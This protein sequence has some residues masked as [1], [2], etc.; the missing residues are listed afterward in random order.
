MQTPVNPRPGRPGQMQS[1]YLN[2]QDRT[3]TTY[4]RYSHGHFHIDVGEAGRGGCALNVFRPFAN[5]RGVGQKAY[6]NEPTMNSTP[7]QMH[8]YLNQ[9]KN[10]LQFISV[11]AEFHPVTGSDF[12]TVLPRRLADVGFS[13]VVA[14][15]RSVV[16]LE[17]DRREN[18]TRVTSIFLA[19]ADTLWYLVE[20]FMT[21]LSGGK[22]F[23]SVARLARRRNDGQSGGTATFR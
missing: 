15:F 12:S 3:A 20:R 23:H 7:R 18:W 22:F 11:I 2:T 14:T 9:M 1:L 4:S 6:N 10:L 21:S 13:A 5:V 8:D 16:L 19:Q 17:S